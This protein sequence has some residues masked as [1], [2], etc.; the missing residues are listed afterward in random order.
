VNV[1]F[2]VAC[3]SLKIWL[4]DNRIKADQQN[5]CCNQRSEFSR[6]PIALSRN[7]NF[8]PGHHQL[9]RETKPASL[10]SHVVLRDC[11]ESGFM[12]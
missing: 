12:V 5:V 7:P 8:D 6:N 1:S 4:V 9:S 11:G 3:L 10:P 2:E